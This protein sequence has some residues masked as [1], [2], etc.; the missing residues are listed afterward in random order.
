MI[1]AQ[2]ITNTT[3]NSITNLPPDTAADVAKVFHD[4]G[5]SVSASTIV[6]VLLAIKASAGYI[7]N[8]ALKNKTADDTGVLGRTIAHVAGNSLPKSVDAPVT[9][10]NPQPTLTQS[11]PPQTVVPVTTPTQVIPNSNIQISS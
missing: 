11:I 2:I 8:F 9:T 7:R 3:G 5:I 10:A 1:L 6:V 4:F